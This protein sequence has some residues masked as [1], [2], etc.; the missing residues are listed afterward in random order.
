M[1]FNAYSGGSGVEQIRHFV[2]CLF[3]YFNNDLNKTTYS[4]MELVSKR[5]WE[6]NDNGV[7][8]HDSEDVIRPMVMCSYILLHA[9]PTVALHGS[10][11]I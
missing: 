5:K 8:I 4:N 1:I 10:H 11:V 9:L 3:I 6:F 2:F 7:N